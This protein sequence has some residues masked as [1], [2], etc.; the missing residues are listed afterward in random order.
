MKFEEIRPWGSFREVQMCER[1]DRRMGDGQGVITIAH[2]GPS[3]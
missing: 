2:P 3:A 1:T